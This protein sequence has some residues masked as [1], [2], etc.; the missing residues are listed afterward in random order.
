MSFQTDDIL[1]FFN[2]TL[3]IRTRQIDFVDHRH[4]IQI[5]IQCQIYIGQCLRLNA[6]CR[7]YDKDCT[8]TGSQAS[9]NLIV[10]IHMPRCV[11]EIEDI[12]L[13][14]FCLVNN[15]NRLRFDSNTTLPLQ[16]HII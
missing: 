12:L 4:N 1:D 5:M 11:D 10:K 6:L 8:I 14:I 9:G 3:R 2:D 15:T 7:I 16:I 13:S